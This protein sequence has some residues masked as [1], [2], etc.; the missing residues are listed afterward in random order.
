M[1][2]KN[3]FFREKQIPLPC[4]S[5]LFQRRYI[6]TKVLGM[7]GFG[8]TYQARD[9]EAEAL[10]AIKELYPA[11]YVRRKNRTARLEPISEKEEDFVYLK[12]R[13]QE[14]ADLLH[15][16]QNRPEILNI[17][18]LF[19]ENGTVY[20]A[21][22][23]LEGETLEKFLKR[24]KYCSWTCLR[25]IAWP[26]LGSVEILHENNLIHRDISPDN[27]FLLNDGKVKLIDF[28]TARNY[29]EADHFTTILKEHFA[30]PEQEISVSRQGPQTDIYELCATFYYALS[31]KLPEKSSMRAARMMETEKDPLIPLQ[32]LAPDV[33]VYVVNALE[34][35][36]QIKMENRFR[37]VFEMKQ[38]LF[39]EQFQH[40]QKKTRWVV[41]IYGIFRGAMWLLEENQCIDLGR[42]P[43]CTIRYGQAPGISRKHCSFFLRENGVVYIRDNRSTYGTYIN[44]RMIMP[45]KW[46]AIEERDE[47]RAGGEY[48]SVR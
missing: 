24:E 16:F 25:K 17:Y 3:G 10:V 29:V 27:I 33:P 43:G 9:T 42:E 37:T 8:I 26:L 18:N 2:L 40:L 12:K 46:Y 35:G 30:P 11:G 15:T 41:C 21:M 44:E 45:G 31:G 19:E 6:I 22:E 36:M 14:E 39:P 1:E 13:F 28:G 5:S 47:I 48:F 20:Y 32:K 34:K 7:G 23:F 4:G 38:A